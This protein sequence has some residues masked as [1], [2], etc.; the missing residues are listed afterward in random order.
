MRLLIGALF[1][2]C[3]QAPLANPF[4]ISGGKSEHQ[5]YKRFVLHRYKGE[6]QGFLLPPQ[7]TGISKHICLFFIIVAQTTFTDDIVSIAILRV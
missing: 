3:F 6:T 5:K 1:S 2:L 4:K 7:N